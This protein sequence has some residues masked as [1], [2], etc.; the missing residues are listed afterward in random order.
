MPLGISGHFWTPPRWFSLEGRFTMCWL[1]PQLRIPPTHRGPS[2]AIT[3]LTTGAGGWTIPVHCTVSWSFH[4]RH[5]PGEGGPF[6]TVTTDNRNLGSRESQ[7]PGLRNVAEAMGFCLW[8]IVLHYRRGTPASGQQPTLG[9]TFWCHMMTRL[10][11]RGMLS[12]GA[13]GRSQPSI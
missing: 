7:S 1:Q 13:Q 9:S 6:L 5:E 11:H 4:H 10:K 3:G 2:K 8:S 12:P